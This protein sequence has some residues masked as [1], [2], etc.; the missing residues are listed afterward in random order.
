MILYRREKLGIEKRKK[1]EK[2]SG[3]KNTTGRTDPT[4]D[5]GKRTTFFFRGRGETCEL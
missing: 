4:Y 1:N 3:H 5:G 2:W